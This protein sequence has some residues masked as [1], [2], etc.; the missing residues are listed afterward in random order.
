VSPNDI[1]GF[2]NRLYSTQL[3]PIDWTQYNSIDS[4]DRQAVVRFGFWNKI[5]TKRESSNYDLVTLQT[6]AD[7][8]FDHNFSAATPNGTL[9]N[10]FNKLT[11]NPTPQLSFQSTSALALD[12]NSYDEIDNS[13][14]WSPDPSLQLTGGDSYI[15]HS[16]VFGDSN[17][18]TLDLFYRM[19][20]HWQFEGQEQFEATTG[21]LQLQQY[22][23]YRDLDA[24][25]LGMTYSDSE[26]NNQ[27]DR[28]V[29]FSLTLKAFPKYQL[30]TPR[31]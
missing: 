26:L 20:E 9:S 30:H 16:T 3:Q 11:F 23:V 14:T 12:A 24:W 15:S 22:T 13:A 2:D 7:A 25:Q 18:V 19:N 29:Y 27:S 6:Y 31:L 4:I 28:S 5:Q 1:R 21:H 8:D 10:L 17:Q